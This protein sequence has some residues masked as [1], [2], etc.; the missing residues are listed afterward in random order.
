MITYHMWASDIN[1]HDS[2]SFKNCSRQL[3]LLIFIFTHMVAL[4]LLIF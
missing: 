2:P 1:Q 4:R 3:E